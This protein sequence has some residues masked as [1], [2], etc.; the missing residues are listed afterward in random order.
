VGATAKPS[1][2]RYTDGVAFG[3]RTGKLNDWRELLCLGLEPDTVGGGFF[4]GK[5][6]ILLNFVQRDPAYHIMTFVGPDRFMNRFVS[7][8]RNHYFL[9][10]GDPDPNLILFPFL[11]LDWHLVFEDTIRKTFAMLQDIKNRR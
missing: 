2:E 7:G 8:P 3:E 10:D 6:D 5:K 4:N 11:A 9:A 1:P